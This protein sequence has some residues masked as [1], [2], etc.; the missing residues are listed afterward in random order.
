VSKAV[1]RYK[2]L[3]ADEAERR[4][5]DAAEDK[6]RMELELKEDGRAEGEVYGRAARDAEI[7]KRLMELGKSEE[8]IAAI[9]G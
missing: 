2:E 4:F 7:A 1:I 3:T 9:L 5:A 6:R 8:E